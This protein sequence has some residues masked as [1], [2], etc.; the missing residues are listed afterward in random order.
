M[1]RYISAWAVEFADA[2]P[3]TQVI[4]T[5]L[6]PIQ[7]T[8]VPPNVSFFVEDAGKEWTF[9]P[10]HFDY[11]HTRALTMG[12]GNWPKLLDQASKALKSGGWIEL[13][14]FHLPLG[15]DDDSMGPETKAGQWGANIQAAC[16]KIGVD[17]MSSL[18][19]PAMLKDAGFTEVQQMSIKVPLGKWVKGDKEKLV[20]Y[21]ARK[22][23]LMGLE[24]MCLK[25]FSLLGYEH[26]KT[27]A[28]IEEMKTEMDSDRVRGLRPEFEL[29]DFA[30]PSIDPR[31]HA[32]QHSVGAKAG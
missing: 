4:G 25:L 18:R 10:A 23:L 13:Q 6:S 22:D 26:D 32:N 2:H 17:T 31:V 21:L 19:H 8:A 3:N 27:M 12:I 16:A 5:D 14:E 9:E 24:G 30:D 20:G 1:T 29:G 11:I 7:P 15:C 28:F